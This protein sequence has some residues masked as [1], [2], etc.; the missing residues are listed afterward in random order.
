MTGQVEWWGTSTAIWIILSRRCY[1]IDVGPAATD[2]PCRSRVRQNPSMAM[3]DRVHLEDDVSPAAWIAPR[4]HPFGQDT[5]SVIPEGFDAYC[6]IFHPEGPNHPD[7]SYETWAEVA[8]ENGR[9]AHSGM[10]YHMINRAPGSPEPEPGSSTSG[11]DVGSLP[12]HL[13]TDLIELLRPATTTPERC[14]FCIWDGYG[15]SDVGNARLVRHPNRNY[16]LFSGP[17]ELATASLDLPWGTTDI[18]WGSLGPNLWWPDDRAWILVTEID[19][20]W[21]YVGGT[22]ELI[23]AVVKDGRLEA[24]KVELSDSPFWNGDTVNAALDHQ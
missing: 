4:L 1:R 20:A 5:G 16:A 24:W 3:D 19:Y 15:Y 21:T 22:S 9:I 23:E 11:P 12:L 14:W 13:R 6:R 2:R 7:D 18:P 10:Q 8:A 17:I